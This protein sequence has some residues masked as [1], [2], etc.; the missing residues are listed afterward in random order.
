MRL[1][2]PAATLAIIGLLLAISG[3]NPFSSP[4]PAANGVV[5]NV[6]VVPGIDNATFALALRKGLFA[7]AGIDV[8]MHQ[9]STVAA[10]LG[11]LNSGAVQVAATDYGDLFFAE[12]SSS[13]IYKILADG[14]DASPGV[15]EIMTLPDSPI[16]SP[17]DLAGRM[18]AYPAT[19]QVPTTAGA[20][21]S[22]AVAAATSVLANYGVNLTT[23]S[24]Q[25]MSPQAEVTALTQKK[26]PAILVTEPYIYQA[27][28]AGAAQ[29]IDACSG[30]TAGL[31][32]S[33]YVTTNAWY[34][35]HP[36]A[37]NAFRL[38]IEQAASLASMPGP[39]QQVLPGYTHLTKQEAALVTVGS[40]PT[41]TI[42][43]SL[44]RTANLMALQ[45]MIRFGLNVDAM[46]IR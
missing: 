6:G 26:V 27:E 15:M 29:L 12:A 44:Q 18:I 13:P 41:S 46:I 42:A 36:S 37:A 17:T 38:A 30:S 11:A 10:A 19:D 39:V 24:W 33:G 40:Y 34:R 4:G 8:R 1:R 35:E 20:P 16:V 9:F 31:P 32:L 23:V 45:G 2:R 25:A 22:L 5:V 3:C 28:Q 43:A 21:T 14:Y 7:S